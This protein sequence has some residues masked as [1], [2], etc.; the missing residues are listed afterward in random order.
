MSD[1]EKPYIVKYYYLYVGRNDIRS[2]VVMAASEFDAKYTIQNEMGRAC[3]EII[4]I[5]ETDIITKK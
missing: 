4:E 5:E 3:A 1:T 2:S